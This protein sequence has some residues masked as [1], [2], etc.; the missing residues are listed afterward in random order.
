MMFDFMH[1]TQTRI[2][3]IDTYAV[4]FIMLMFL[5]MCKYCKTDFGRDGTE[6]PLKNL[7]W[8]GIFFGLGVAS[9]WTCIYA[10]AGLAVC[11]FIHFFMRYKNKADYPD[12]SKNAARIILS[13]IVFFVIIPLLIYWVSYIPYAFI[14]DS[15]RDIFYIFRIQKGMFDYHA[16]LDAE[17][18]FSS[19]WYQWPIMYKP[20]WYFSKNITGTENVSSISAFGNPALW[21]VSLPATA[22]MLYFMIKERKFA[23]PGFIIIGYLAQYLPWVGVSRVVFIYHYFTSVPFIIMI[24]T[25]VAVKLKE[26]MNPKNF[27]MLMSAY[28]TL[29]VLLFVMFYPAISGFEV[30]KAYMKNIL[31]WFSTWYFGG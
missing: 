9:K 11:F 17:H 20:M 19:Y 1:F 30:P 5:F 10:G 25:Y 14:K 18:F 31:M 24:V 26:R 7:L 21:W 2:A 4:F 13:C 27:R 22:A 23:V 15:P 16:D 12:F 28:C 6:K 8:C 3:T 29:T